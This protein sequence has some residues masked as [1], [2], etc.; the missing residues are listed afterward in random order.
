MRRL[1]LFHLA[2]ALIAL[3]A[4]LTA[5]P[6]L[7]SLVLPT[8]QPATS[9][10]IY[11]EGAT[12]VSR[13]AHALEEGGLRVVPISTA[14]EPGGLGS[15]PLL[16]FIPNPQLCSG[17]SLSRLSNLTWSLA[18][19]GARVAVLVTGES[20]CAIS[21]VETVSRGAV[22]LVAVKRVEGLGVAVFRCGGVRGYF[23]VDG[24]RHMGYSL[25]HS[26]KAQ[27][28]AVAATLNST[29]PRPLGYLFTVR[30]GHAVLRVAFIADGDAFTNR[31][32]NIS[33][34]VGLSDDATL[35]R[36]AR[37]LAGGNATVLVPLDFYPASVR[38]SVVQLYVDPGSLMARFFEKL[39][40]L[41]LEALKLAALFPGGPIAL[42]GGLL[43]ALSLLI[44][45]LRQEPVNP[46]AGEERRGLL[47]GLLA[48]L[49]IAYGDYA[50]ELAGELAGR[51]DGLLRAAYGV[52][53]EEAAST[54]PPRGDSAAA[55]LW[56]AARKALKLLERARTGRVRVVRIS[57]VRRVQRLVEEAAE[58]LAGGRT[59]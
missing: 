6:H 19:S 7:V 20:D 16:L 17:E 26:A 52:G 10:P 5:P 28:L 46:K 58:L 40:E 11:D 37:C 47:A 9:P 53:V 24:F 49:G 18:R 14:V 2:L 51:V 55:L 13:V 38:A 44:P 59:S 39:A 25:S 56:A 35:V 57:E 36:L 15:G 31:L 45:Q 12:G 29:S 8:G 3:I 50:V 1:R 27:L 54:E 48:R 32:V 42:A 30:E 33:R 41:E 43:L 34:G 21:I 22:S 23:V 4:A